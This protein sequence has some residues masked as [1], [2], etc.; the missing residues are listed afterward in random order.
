MKKSDI[1][2]HDC[3]A[4]YRRIDLISRKG[5]PGAYRYLSVKEFWRPLMALLR[6]PIVRLLLQGGLR[7][8]SL[9]EWARVDVTADNK[10]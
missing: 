1:Q 7:V 3:A 2:C 10:A 9:H 6:L 5:K 8:T 4:G